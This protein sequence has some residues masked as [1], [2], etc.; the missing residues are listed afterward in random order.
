MH[1]TVKEQQWY[2]S[3]CCQA[4][5][6]LV[7]AFVQGKKNTG[8]TF[9]IHIENNMKYQ[10]CFQELH[11]FKNIKKI[12]NYKDF[13][14]TLF[15]KI[16]FPLKDEFNTM[17]YIHCIYQML[18]QYTKLEAGKYFFSAKMCKQRKTTNCIYLTEKSK[19]QFLN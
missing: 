18:Y 8:I 11:F 12:A 10:Q 3:M 9:T 7:C 4:K 16:D 2:T 15:V 13:L 1:K 5:V 14:L 17:E 19:L 6:Y